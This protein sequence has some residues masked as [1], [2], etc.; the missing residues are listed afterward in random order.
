MFFAPGITVAEREGLCRQVVD[1]SKAQANGFKA[2]YKDVFRDPSDVNASAMLKGCH[3]HYITQVARIKGNRGLIMADE[4]PEFFERCMELLKLPAAG[5]PNHEERVD[6]IRRRYPKIRKWLDWWTMADVEAMLFPSRRPML[7]DHPDGNDGLPDTTNAQESLHRL[8]YMFSDGKASLLVGMVDMFAFVTMLAE[9]WHAVMRGVSINY[10]AQKVKDIGLTL[11]MSQKRKR[12]ANDGRPPDTTDALVEI[13]AQKPKHAKLGRPRNSPNINKTPGSVFASYRAAPSDSDRANRCWM[14]AALEGLYALYTPLWIRGINGK[15]N[16]LF[17]YLTKHFSSRK[18]YEMTMAG[19]LGS[20][21]SKAQGKFFDMARQAYPGRFN[22]G[23][24]A[25]CDYFIEILLDPKQHPK[26]NHLHNLFGF[27]IRREFSCEAHPDIKQA[28]LAM[29]R[30]HHVLTIS[31]DMF[32]EAR[33]SYGDVGKLL[34]LWETD[35]LPLHSGR[36]CKSCLESKPLFKPPTPTKKKKQAKKPK[37][38]RVASEVEVLTDYIN[39]SGDNQHYLLE[40]S[41]LHFPDDLPPLHLNIHLDVTS[42]QDETRKRDFM[43]GTDWPFKLTLGGYVYTLL[44]C[45]FWNTYHYWGK[46]LQ[47]SAGMTGVWLHNDADNHGYAQLINRVPGSIA[48]KAPHT[49]WLLYSRTWTPS[50]TQFMEESIEKIRRDN[51]KPVG[52]LPFLQAKALLH[53]LHASVAIPHNPTMPQGSLSAFQS[54]PPATSHSNPPTTTLQAS[55]LSQV[56]PTQ[57]PSFEVTPAVEDPSPAA[58]SHR[59]ILTLTQVSANTSEN[60]S[61]VH[62]N[63]DMSDLCALLDSVQD[64]DV[65]DNTGHTSQPSN[66]EP[67]PNIPS[68]PI[69]KV[70]NNNSI[71]P[72]PPPRLTL[73]LKRPAPPVSQGPT[74]HSTTSLSNTVP[75]PVLKAVI[76]PDLMVSNLTSTPGEANLMPT[77]RSTRAKS[78]KAT[79]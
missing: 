38:T 76:D 65:Y 1:F 4:E 21:L 31:S 24:F 6:H 57:V 51:P 55:T 69:Q 11:G 77:R 62:D 15:G 2:A 37:I 73:K 70:F 49:S 50:E 42:I 35:G 78:G 9:D 54:N 67:K 68:D 48:G 58:L 52:E 66:T 75:K 10:G 7:E 40:H 34:T 71:P 44:A 43:D 17:T 64:T 20:I 8:Y 29:E 79:H 3:Q 63:R 39:I 56:T 33:L 47:T 22:P 28:P 36:V 16:D 61:V 60:L 53:S 72:P 30:T 41:H 59:P 23:V 14:A 46:V 19:S 13:G 32:G 26:N 5:E 25:S 27:A 18:T 12:Y 74:P 45:G